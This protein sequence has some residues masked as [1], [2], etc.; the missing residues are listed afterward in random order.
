MKKYDVVIIGGGPAG[1][2]LAYPLKSNGQKVAVVEENLWGGTCPNRGCDPKKVLL[3][4]VEAKR[5]GEYLVEKGIQDTPEINWDDL[6]RFEKTFTAPVSSGSKQGLVNAGIDVLDGHAEFES[7]NILSVGSDKIESDRF[8]VA[9]GQRPG[10]LNINGDELLQTSTDF[11]NMDHLP[12]SLVFVGGGYIAF[13]FAAI[14]VAAGAEVHLIH[15]NDRPLKGFPKDGVD[16]LINQL[17]KQGV[18]FHFN[19]N[20]NKIVKDNSGIELS[21]GQVFDL[22]V[23]KGFVT[24]G[25]RPN[26]DT[27]NLNQIGVETDQHGIEVNDHLQT[28]VENIYAMGD[29]V[30]RKQP[31]L[32][33]VSGF[34]AQ[35][36][37]HELLKGGDGI[38][39]P[40]IP[41]LV[42]GMPKLAQVGLSVEEAQKQAN[43]YDINKLDMTG[44][45][46]YKRTNEPVSKAEVVIEKE[47]NRI[48]G[49][50][51]IS[52]EADTV[53]NYLTMIINAKATMSEVQSQIFAYPTEASDLEYFG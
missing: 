39:Y 32:T 25:R 48:V 29:V 27:L 28:T 16:E 4:A 51:V 38:T 44:W 10:R 22:K 26:D 9:T 24:A 43:K 40:A 35:Y 52:S 34:E 2:G 15:H 50:F 14:A 5:K 13:E 37:S 45:F 42:Y 11:L 47:S 12:K 30:S 46:S 33:P 1:L 20:I 31:K 17:K 19:V 41:T 8:V 18:Q 53:I 7:A 21:D 36:L 6:M 49:A 3:S 23:S